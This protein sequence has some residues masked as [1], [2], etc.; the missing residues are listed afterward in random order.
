MPHPRE[1][2]S[3]KGTNLKGGR[4]MRKAL[5]LGAVLSSV[6]LVFATNGS[7]LIGVTPASRAMGGIGVGAPVGPVDSI[8][9]NPAWMSVMEDKFTAQF[10]GIL[11]MPRVQARIANPLG[12]S[13]YQKSQADTFVAPEIGMVHRISDR[14]VF[15]IGAF[16]TSGMGV[17][18]RNNEN[19]VAAQGGGNTSLV[20]MHTSFQ[21][22]R[23]IPAVAYQVNDMITISGAIHGAWGSLDMGAFLCT[24][25]GD[26]T[27]CWNAG[28]GQSQALGVGVQVGAS[29]NF[30]DFL[31]AGLTYQSPVSMTYKRVFDSDGD[32]RFEDLK[33]Q[34][35]QEIALGIGAAPL[36][37]LKIGLDV[38]WINWGSA[39]GYKDFQWKDQIVYAVGAEYRPME[40]LSL[41]AG[42]NYGRSPIEGRSGLSGTL[43]SSP[44]IPDLNQPFSDFNIAFFNLLGFPAISESHLTLGLGYEFTRTFAIDLSYVHAFN[45]K[46]ESSGTYFDAGA[47]NAGCPT[48][49]GA[50][51]SQNSISLGL[52]W[53]F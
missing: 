33:L 5:L 47:C 53:R 31:Y 20:N 50:Q 35:P 9:R 14:L 24:D 29:L 52:N 23:I 2:K 26:P 12:D 22:M 46:V 51:M 30:G 39:Q 13:G 34:Q 1:L 44:N 18:Y 41:R 42:F 6:G 11:F 40:K 32:G 45:N 10:G 15:G 21:F 48:T 49:V 37:G 25:A 8:F 4:E 16:G 27:T 43:P 36:N 38:R 17:D 7:N 19:L 3:L 28:G